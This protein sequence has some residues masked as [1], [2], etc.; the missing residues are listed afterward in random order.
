MLGLWL[1]PCLNLPLRLLCFLAPRS[2]FRACKYRT[3]YKKYLNTR[4]SQHT[5][6]IHICMKILNRKS[7]GTRTGT[8]T[9]G[10]RAHTH[11]LETTN[12]R[13]RV[14]IRLPGDLKFTL[15]HSHSVLMRMC[16][17]EGTLPCWL[18]RVCGTQLHKTK[19]NK[20][21]SAL[22]GHVFVSK[23]RFSVTNF[24][25]FLRF[26]SEL[27]SSSRSFRCTQFATCA[28]HRSRNLNL[29]KEVRCS[30]LV[31]SDVSVQHTVIYDVL[32]Q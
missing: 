1:K 31:K 19:W 25:N 2:Y 16:I 10:A 23:N 30:P 17:G 26:L 14:G 28:V 3:T 24:P 21:K 20:S 29:K 9:L 15:S 11:R 22:L 4:A 8:R 12:G 32:K 18:F 6:V 7:T 5:Y 13:G 27:Y